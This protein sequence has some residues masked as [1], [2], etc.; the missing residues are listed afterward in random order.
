MPE[1]S[2]QQQIIN[3]TSRI[4]IVR[5]APGSGKTWLVG[6]I[7]QKELESWNQ[8]GG[9]AALSFT[10]VGGEEI[11]KAVGYELTLPHFI[12]TLDSFLFKYI[13][14]PFLSKCYKLKEPRLIPSTYASE[15]WSSNIA[16]C[17]FKDSGK[18]KSYN[19][20]DIDYGVPR[21]GNIKFLYTP[22][23]GEKKE[24]PSQHFSEIKKRKIDIWE[25]IGWVSHS[26]V[27]F[28]AFKILESQQGKCIIKELEKRF[29]FIIVD[30][31]QD[32][33]Y[34][35]CEFI[36]KILSES[37]IKALLVGDPNQSIYEFNGATPEMFD[38]FKELNGAHEISLQESRRCPQKIINVANQIIP[39][40]SQ[41]KTINP[42]TGNTI[43]LCYNKAFFSEEVN[44]A[45]YKIQNEY[46]R[47]KIIKAITRNSSTINEL[48]HHCGNKDIKSI[49]SQ[50]LTHITRGVQQFLLKQNSKALCQT[51]DAL[52]LLLFQKE[53]LSDDEIK[54]RNIDPFLWKELVCEILLNCTNEKINQVTYK[55]WQERAKEN[56]CR[57]LKKSFLSNFIDETEINK[58]L[59]PKKIGS[60]SEQIN[61]FLPIPQNE[62]NSIPLLTV[63]G[64]KGETHDVTIFICPP[65]K[66][67]LLCP[68][69]AWWFGEE[70]R[71]TFVALTRSR[72]DLYL[73]VS[74]ET[75][76]N[77]MI[78]H[79]P[80]Y[81]CFEVKNIEDFAPKPN[82]TDLI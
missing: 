48:K 7:I 17:T 56:I 73:V 25:K 58:M 45:I 65:Q 9:I 18:Y 28:L 35:I 59:K 74:K 60:A 54:E 49:G 10:R 50:V 15:F 52:T 38:T 81:D 14:K 40:G 29:Q 55:E 22:Y 27:H 64:V 75:A 4:R 77:L 34:Y 76:R 41:I 36:R 78:N 80:F 11:R 32:T 37:N 1:K 20:L 47:N 21:N 39:D 68:S 67:G 46:S 16:R 33:G 31:L 71:I 2:T 44:Q 61:M 26:D 82:W 53:G 19:L 5:A 79:K 30:E 69:D 42:K 13:V 70:R 72:E 6:Q 3:D 43:M 24:V 66:K 51:S 57:I 63:H 12:G 8:P 62:T 23:S